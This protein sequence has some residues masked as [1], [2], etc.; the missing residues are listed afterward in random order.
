MS[1][2]NRTVCL[3]FLFVNLISLSIVTHNYF[4]V[5]T[6]MRMASS[7]EVIT[8]SDKEFINPDVALEV[9]KLL[10]VYEQE[11]YKNEEWSP[12]V[13]KVKFARPYMGVTDDWRYCEKH[14][15]WFVHNP[16]VVFDDKNMMT[17]YRIRAV[18][19]TDVLVNIGGKDVMPQVHSRM[20]E[21]LQKVKIFDLRPDIN[22]YFTTHDLFNYRHIG[23][24]FSCTTQM[25][26]HIPGHDHLYRKD[27]NAISLLKYGRNVYQDRPECFSEKKFFPKTYIMVD[28]SQ[29]E[30][31]FKVWTGP[32]YERLK[33]E[34]NGLV[35]IR[36]IGEGAHMGEGVFPV[37]A[38]QEEYI[39]NLYKNGS[40]C[41]QVPENNLMQYA[42]W[43]PLLL[44]G[45]KFDFRMFM[46]IAST[47]PTMVYYRDG[48]LRVSLRDYDPKSKEIG[49]IL[50]N[51]ALSKPFFEEAK[52]KG[53]YNGYTEEE[54]MNQAFWSMPKLND[55][56][57][58]NKV[59]NDP[60]WLDNYLRPEF[61]RAMI[62]LI[63]MSQATFS[64]KSSV[65]EIF[66][67]D[68]MLDDKLNLWFIEA[69]AQPLLDGWS[70]D[71]KVFF[72]KIL[73]DSFDI[74]YGLLRSR[75]KRIVKFV[76]KLIQEDQVGQVNSNVFYIEDLNAK[77]KEFKEIS[78]NYFEPD[79]SMSPDN[80]YQLI[81]DDNL[82][83]M[84]RYM[85]LIESKCL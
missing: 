44:N 21:E 12:E 73:Y 45:R 49:S 4:T 52:E 29:C 70:D 19:R 66:G 75:T 63:R 1:S 30:E 5:G 20:P 24:Q 51:I 46:L 16:S 43:N 41:G 83:G 33:E 79:F 69:N 13:A 28:K 53:T 60:N 32:E 26:N 22:H 71:T 55:Y 59:V 72:N 35:Y 2:P 84:D 62:H 65:Y 23:K 42:V 38:T 48:F 80:D 58:K 17:N 54:L 6:S 8:P 18:L 39:S 25:S 50:T 10:D 40:L 77:R 67:L 31:F 15:E 34:R 81:L 37:N 9:L 68:F 11:E 14:R 61:K 74:V 57:Y 85:G 3:F 78:K 47:N 76:N 7:T 36:K 64:S 56:L 27:Y 82:Q